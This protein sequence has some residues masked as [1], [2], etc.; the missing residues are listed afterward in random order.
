MQV[1]AHY[2]VN[3]NVNIVLLVIKL[4]EA[5]ST[6]TTKK[7]FQIVCIYICKGLVDYWHVEIIQKEYKIYH[8]KYFGNI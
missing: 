4:C 5:N 3:V 6:T 8:L 1:N 7:H 2:N